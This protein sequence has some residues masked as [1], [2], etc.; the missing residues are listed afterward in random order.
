[1][2]IKLIL[3]DQTIFFDNV[4]DYSLTAA[5]TTGLLIIRH[6]EN[7]IDYFR[8]KFVKNWTVTKEVKDENHI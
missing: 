4:N 7:V 3:I 6:D 8:M 2:R 5:G 1:M